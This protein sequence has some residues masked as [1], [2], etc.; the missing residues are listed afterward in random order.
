MFLFFSSFLFNSSPV[1]SI[2]SSTLNP[3]ILS[4]S[5]LH[6]PI[7]LPLP[8]LFSLSSLFPPTSHPLSIH[9]PPSTVPSLFLPFPVTL[10]SIPLSPSLSVPPFSLFSPHTLSLNLPFLLLSFLPTPSSLPPPPL[11]SASLPR[12]TLPFHLTS[13]FFIP[14]PTLPPFELVYCPRLSILL[15]PL[16]KSL[17]ILL[18]RNTTI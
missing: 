14:L 17:N 8:S 5:I 15:K 13:L 1:F 12:S 7:F 9:C 16:E 2:S 10:F 11:P 6:L 4:F 18:E 3:I